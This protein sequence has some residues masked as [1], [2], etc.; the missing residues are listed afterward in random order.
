MAKLF[1]RGWKKLVLSIG[2]KHFYLKIES[3]AAFSAD[4]NKKLHW[5]KKSQVSF[6]PTKSFNTSLSKSLNC[7]LNRNQSRETHP[8]FKHLAEGAVIQMAWDAKE[9]R[10]QRLATP[11]VAFV[12]DH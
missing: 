6:Y 2:E 9:Y 3:K 8:G 5:L 4:Y 10:P 12:T 11:I 7:R 1:Q